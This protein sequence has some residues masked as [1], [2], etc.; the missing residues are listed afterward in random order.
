MRTSGMESKESGNCSPSVG[1]SFAL[2]V[3][4]LL[5]VMAVLRG[6][7]GCGGSGAS[8]PVPDAAGGEGALDRARSFERLRP[9]RIRGD[10]SA[11][12]GRHIRRCGAGV[13]PRGRFKGCRHRL[14]ALARTG[15]LSGPAPRRGHRRGRPSRERTWISIGTPPRSAPTT[16]SIPRLRRR[17]VKPSKGSIAS[18]VDT[19]ETALHAGRRHRT[20]C[21]PFTTTRGD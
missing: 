7:G 20:S 21:F 1:V 19:G 8:S 2:I 14:R 3:F 13:R 11:R 5:G 17:K 18:S 6:G 16:L 4:R 10:Q 12:K 15:S 9:E